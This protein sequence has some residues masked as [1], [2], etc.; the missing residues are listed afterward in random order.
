MIDRNQN[1]I[2]SIDGKD[3]GFRFSTWA[4]KQ[5][6]QRAGCKGVIQ[7]FKKI[8]LEDNDL[9]FE[10]LS[11]LAMEARNDYIYTERTGEESITQR[12]A[13]DIIDKTGG[14]MDFL[15]KIS[16]GLA[17]HLPKNQ[18]PPQRAGETIQ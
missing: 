7:L 8:G 15:Q 11:L 16:E 4:L 10:T 18:E 17:S 13:C 3:Y 1:V 12:M 14:V 6:Q 5:T 2:L 9:D